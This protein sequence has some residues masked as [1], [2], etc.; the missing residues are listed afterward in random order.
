[1]LRASN[2]G[3]ADCTSRSPRCADRCATARTGRTAPAPAHRRAEKAPGRAH[4]ACA[5]IPAKPLA[6]GP[7]RRFFYNPKESCTPRRMA[8]FEHQLRV[9]FQHTDPAGIVFFTNILVYCHEAYEEFLR[10]GGMPLEDFIG[11]REQT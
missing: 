10:A 8:P 3:S 2:T 1:P 4:P 7:P 6:G 9:R 5:A 11:K